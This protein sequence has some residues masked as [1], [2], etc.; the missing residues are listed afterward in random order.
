MRAIC[1]T[2][3]ERLEDIAS[4]NYCLN[5]LINATRCMRY[6]DIAVVFKQTFSH[7]LF[8]FS[9]ASEIFV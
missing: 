2:A 4:L 8:K 5:R 1:C 6:A 9:N 3:T 7:P